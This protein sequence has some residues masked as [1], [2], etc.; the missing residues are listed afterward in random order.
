MLA[1]TCAGIC[2]SNSLWA[3]KGFSL[4]VTAQPSASSVH[5]DYKENVYTWNSNY[6]QIIEKS[7]T[8]AMQAGIEADYHFTENIGIGLGLLYS[9]QGQ[10]YKDLLHSENGYDAWY[11][12]YTMNYTISES[13][14]LNY[15]KLPLKFHF[16]T[17]P[18]KAVSFSGS[19]G[20]YLAFLTSY[21]VNYSMIGTDYSDTLGS[22]NFNITQVA[23]G[24]TI[25]E[26]DIVNGTSTITTATF[27]SQPFKSTD[28]G[29]IIGVGMQVKLSDKMY[30]PI[31][32]NYEI[33]FSDVKDLSSA[34]RDPIGNINYTWDATNP[35]RSVSHN[36]SVMGLMIGLKF[37]L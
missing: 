17:D 1:L 24:S 29:G 25:T 23:H 27:T 8:F 6:Y 16:N 7:F 11:G 13:W 21:K 2:L 36:N 14:A 12:N 9:S 15:L 37:C 22:D 5:G 35:N 31:L 4:T 20:I 3:Q 10:K 34:F 32:F 19:I 28:M 18:S 33:G 30:L 26:T